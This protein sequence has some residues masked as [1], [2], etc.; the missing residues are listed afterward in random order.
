M[1]V[2][3]NKRNLTNFQTF[4]KAIPKKQKG[5][6]KRNLLI[7]LR[8]SDYKFYHRL[9]HNAFL[10]HERAIISQYFNLPQEALFPD[11]PVIF[12]G[13]D[14]DKLQIINSKNLD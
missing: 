5:L 1:L 14:L 4:W 12:H 13:V 2:S 6:H 3:E 8:L 10:P 11:L 7:I 9:R